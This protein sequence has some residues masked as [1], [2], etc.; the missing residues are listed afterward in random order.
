L[1]ERTAANIRP[2]RRPDGAESG[3]RLRTGWPAELRLAGGRRIRCTVVDL[4]SAGARIKLDAPA[5]EFRQAR[6][7][8]DRLPPVAAALA[9]RR[10]D[11]LGLTFLAEQGWVIDLCAQRFDPAAWLRPR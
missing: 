2:L 10:R 3:R 11:Q 7:V 1:S 6:L 9:W 4:S 5:V 8:I